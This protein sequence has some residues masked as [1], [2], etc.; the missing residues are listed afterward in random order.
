MK[1][2]EVNMNECEG[3]FINIQ[4]IKGT[5]EVLTTPP[6]VVLKIYAKYMKDYCGHFRFFPTLSDV[7][8]KPHTLSP[9]NL[10]GFSLS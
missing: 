9:R 2:K 1:Y 7:D 10:A 8:A 3:L 4:F 5:D 6:S